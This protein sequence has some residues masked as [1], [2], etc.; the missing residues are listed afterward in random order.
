MGKILMVVSGSRTGITNGWETN[1]NYTWRADSKVGQRRVRDD[2]N[3]AH[4]S[5]YL[6]T[7]ETDSVENVTEL[8]KNTDEYIDFNHYNEEPCGQ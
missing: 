7:P 4:C 8:F 5:V 6:Y 1:I 3:R 2:I